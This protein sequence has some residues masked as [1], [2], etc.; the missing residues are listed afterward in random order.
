[1]NTRDYSGKTLCVGMHVINS[2]TFETLK[3]LR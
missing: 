1:M 2:G 3:P